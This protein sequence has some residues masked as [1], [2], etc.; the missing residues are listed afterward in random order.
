M[1]A[2]Y[3]F[4]VRVLVTRGRLIALGSLGALAVVLGA[5]VGASSTDERARIAIGL[6]ETYGLAGLAP[7]TSL[8]FASAVFGDLVEDQ[9]LVHIWLRPIARG[10]ITIAAYGA[11]LTV[12]VP[13]VVVPLSA[14]AALSGKGSAIVIGTVVAALAATTVYCSL[15]CFLGLW[16]RR[17]LVWGLV[18]ILIWEGAIAN[19]GAGLARVALRLYTRSLLADLSDNVVEVKYG[20]ALAT[21]L[22]VPAIVTA[23]VLVLTTH[24]LTRTEVA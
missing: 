22:A 9:T 20:V 21:G 2:L 4:F 3:R 13:L 10:R 12:V 23:V 7:V 11:V 18:Y 8:V 17:S 19:V 24:R 6:I 15:F 14:A 5:A 16:I 1:S